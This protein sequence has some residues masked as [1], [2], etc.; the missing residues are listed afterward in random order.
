MDMDAIL[1]PAFQSAMPPAHF[2]KSLPIFAKDSPVVPAIRVFLLDASV[3]ELLCLLW[4]N[5]PEVHSPFY[6]QSDPS[7]NGSVI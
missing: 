6:S 5:H 7:K 4:S 3:C 1:I 2:L